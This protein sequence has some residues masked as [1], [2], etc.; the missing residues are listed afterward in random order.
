MADKSYVL[1]VEDDPFYS[2]VYKAKVEKEGIRAQI[3]S[4][5][6]A[7]LKA[8]RAEKPTLVVLDLIMAGKDGFQTLAEL[9]ADAATKDVKVIVLSNLSQEEDVKRVLELGAAEYHIKADISIEA[10]M[11]II[12][13]HMA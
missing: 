11:Q 7:A 5:G 10:L 2:S 8:I 9:K 6:G 3:V 12:K 4:D 1:I 13:G